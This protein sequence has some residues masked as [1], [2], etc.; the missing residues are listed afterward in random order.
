[1]SSC[2]SKAGEPKAVMNSP[3]STR[4]IREVRRMRRSAENPE[5][6]Q[7]R[8]K[9]LKIRVSSKVRLRPITGCNGLLERGHRRGPRG[10]VFV[11][12]VESRGGTRQAHRSRVIHLQ[13]AQS[14]HGAGLRPDQGAARLPALQPARPGEC[15]PRVETGVLTSSFDAAGPG[16]TQSLIKAASGSIPHSRATHV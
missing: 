1:M 7:C 2:A 9:R 8:P 15:A 13:D 16:I 10:Q 5:P 12:G 11:R 14:D 3:A 4:T 6:L